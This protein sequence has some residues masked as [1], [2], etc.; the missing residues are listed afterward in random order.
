MEHQPKDDKTGKAGVDQR[1]P[2]DPLR[3]VFVPVEGK[4][5]DGTSSFKTRDGASYVRGTDGVIRRK[6]P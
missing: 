1:L 3:R 6:R 2:I 5:L 4:N